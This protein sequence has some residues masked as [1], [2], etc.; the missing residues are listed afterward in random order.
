MTLDHDSQEVRTEIDIAGMREDPHEATGYGRLVDPNVPPQFEAAG[1]AVRP[2]AADTSG[3]YHPIDTEA[4]RTQEVKTDADRERGRKQA[5]LAKE[6]IKNSTPP[7]NGAFVPNPTPN[8][9][10]KSFTSKELREGKGWGP[11]SAS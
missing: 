10:H 3:P 11:F 8:T 1:S 4:L 6:V 9:P 2:T 5:V 7:Q